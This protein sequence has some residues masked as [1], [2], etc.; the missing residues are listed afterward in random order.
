V[1]LV[2][3]LRAKSGDYEVLAE[4]HAER[5]PVDEQHAVACQAMF[6]VGVVLRELAAAIDLEWWEEADADADTY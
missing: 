1:S 2:A 6:V 4:P 5:A 3:Y